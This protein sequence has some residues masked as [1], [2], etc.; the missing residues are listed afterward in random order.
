MVQQIEPGAIKGW[1]DL[2]KA[3]CENFMGIITHPSHM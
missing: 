3:F 1:E 2:K